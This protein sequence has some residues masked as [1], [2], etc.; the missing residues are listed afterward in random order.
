LLALSALVAGC[1]PLTFSQ[2][3]SI[4]FAAYPSVRLEIGGPDGSQRQLDY[5]ESE[6]RE[7]SG[8]ASI[9]R[10]P[11]ASVSA[12]LRAELELRASDDGIFSSSDDEITYS[13]TL[14]Y[15]LAATSGEVIE[16]GSLSVS[17]EDTFDDA[18]EAAADQLVLHYLRPYRL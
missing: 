3:E 11:A 10:D 1:A 18:A 16:T 6:L 5:L 14:A 9:T 8:F 12:L 13:C 4:D 17:E 15:R 2:D 7:H